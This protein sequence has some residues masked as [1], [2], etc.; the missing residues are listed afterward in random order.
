MAAAVARRGRAHGVWRAISVANIDRKVACFYLKIKGSIYLGNPMEMNANPEKSGRPVD[1]H[2]EWAGSIK[3]W[4]RK[5]YIW[6]YRLRR[7][8]SEAQE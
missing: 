5:I 4:S 2:E 1:S 3:L 7:C 8:L 6:T